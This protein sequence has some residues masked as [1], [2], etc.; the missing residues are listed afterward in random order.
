M[1][2]DLSCAIESYSIEDFLSEQDL[3]VLKTLIR[4]NRPTVTIVYNDCPVASVFFNL[5]STFITNFFE[6]E[7]Y[8]LSAIQFYLERPEISELMADKL[9]AEGSKKSRIS[10]IG[11]SASRYI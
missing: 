9:I 2:S 3:E 11:E 8:N 6:E 4:T 10:L 7:N 1:T 5:L